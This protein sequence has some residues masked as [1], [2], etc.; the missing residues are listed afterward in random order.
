MPENDARL[1]CSLAL[2]RLVDLGYGEKDLLAWLA[3]DLEET[4][5]TKK[6]HDA[7]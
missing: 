3:A 4:I 5:A 6:E 7:L 2:I 1:L